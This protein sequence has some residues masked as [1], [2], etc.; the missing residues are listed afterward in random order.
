[1]MVRMYSQKDGLNPLELLHGALDH[2]SAS[3]SLFKGSPSHYDSAGY[4]AHLGLEL[5]LKSWLLTVRGEFD[6]IHELHSL[7]AK[8]VSSG[9]AESL[10]SEDADT[11]T[12]LDEYSELRYPNLN[13]PV[14]VGTQQ[15]A[16][17]E[18]L[19]DTLWAQIP[20]SLSEAVHSMD[21]L[22]KGGRVLMKKKI[23]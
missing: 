20:A 3:K 13:Q 17:V 15:Q 8:L 7:H 21:P 10:S 4:L 9:T 2:L 14:E 11:M 23:E 12:L 18:L 19:M 6:G 22:Q 16:Q 1:M 5:T